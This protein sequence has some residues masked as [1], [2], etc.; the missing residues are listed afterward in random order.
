MSDTE[1]LREA[2]SGDVAEQSRLA[3]D[4]IDEADFDT[5]EVGLE[6]DPADFLEQQQSIPT[7]PDD[8]R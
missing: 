8:R 3:D 5:T 2:D 7:D 1:P 4:S 6:C